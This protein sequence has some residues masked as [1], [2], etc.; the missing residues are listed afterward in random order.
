MNQVRHSV[1]A[2]FSVGPLPVAAG[3][4]DLAVA[5]P[6]YRAVWRWHFYAGLVCLPFL[7]TM[8]VTGALYLFRVE[9]EPIVYRDLLIV[10][11]TSAV[12]R[13]A[14]R[15]VD[16]ALAAQPGT[17]V[18]YVPPAASDR[19]AEVGV[20]RPDGVAV[21][22][23]VDPRSGQ[24]LGTLRDDRKLMQVIRDLHSLAIAGTVA[25][26]WIE[27]VAGWAIVLVTTGVFMWWPR[28][29]VGGVV[30]VRGTPKRRMWWRDLHAVTGIIGASVVLFLAVTGMPWPAFWGKQFNA[31][32]TKWGLGIP[33]AVWGAVPR[34][35]EPM[36]HHAEVPW[37]LSQAMLPQSTEEVHRARPI[38]LDAAMRIFDG[39]RVDTGYSVT[40]PVD[41]NGVYSAMLFPD[42]VTRVRVV[43]LDQYSG[44]PLIDLGYRDYGAVAKVTEW[45]VAIHT[46]RLYGLVNQ[47][48]MLT[49]CIAIATLAVTSVVMWWKR[50]PRGRL[51]APVRKDG[52][53]VSRTVVVIAVALGLLYPLVGASMLV[54]LLVD[55]LVPR[56]WRLRFG[57]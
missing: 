34:S 41:S 15:L 54:A 20:R 18:R 50:R 14:E 1:D 3:G 11:P 57:L 40:L 6:L 42:D 17:A 22:V 19:S 52:D 43:H 12:P 48:V 39:L 38:G 55:A 7:F 31:Y 5:S 44:K 26:H 4:G 56:L 16:A 25:N 47:L 49:G 29:R 2:A 36:A 32:T 24:V 33:S 45:G 30:S 27:I 23:Y 53:R 28:G 13:S 10:T 37:T 35:N 46:G 21:S 9:I 51:A 8:A